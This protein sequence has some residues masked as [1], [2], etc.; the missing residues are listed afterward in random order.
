LQSAT[1]ELQSESAEI[2]DWEFSDQQ[3]DDVLHEDDSAFPE[4]WPIE[5]A[6]TGTTSQR[7]YWS[8]GALAVGALLALQVAHHF[9][10]NLSGMPVIG[11]PM[12]T[13]YAWL[14]SP[15]PGSW[16][17]GAY[18]IVNWSTASQ[19]EPNSTDRL[20]FTASIR[21]VSN[22]AK[23]LP[24]VH[25]KLTDRWEQAIGSRYFEPEEYLADS[26]SRPLELAGGATADIR[27]DLVD[28]GPS[29]YGFEVDVCVEISGQA[30]RCSA[31]RVF[32]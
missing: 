22:A 5:T 15:L 30:L 19:S 14:G 1:E 16:T 10:E 28:P 20:S 8:V 26:D 31:D 25:L 9:R 3:V 23:P 12:R 2:T 24:L 17:P 13:V 32:Q 7:N 21:N 18:E 11:Q 6:P 27:L 29:A 4:S